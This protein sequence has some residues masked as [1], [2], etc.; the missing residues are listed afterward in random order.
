MKR[1]CF[2]LIF[3]SSICFG[4][5]VEVN[6]IP[7]ASF[8]Q[9]DKKVFKVKVFNRLSVP[10]AIKC[11]MSFLNYSE[12]DTLK[13]AIG[14]WYNGDRENYYYGIDR[15]TTDGNSSSTNPFHLII[16]KVMNLKTSWAL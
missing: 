2:L 4:Q 11:S 9:K 3:L 1:F 10:I 12:Q 8:H 16:L 5:D 7:D 13:V 6:L 14:E 15:S